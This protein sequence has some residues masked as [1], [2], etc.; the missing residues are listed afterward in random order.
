MV[1]TVF[2]KCTYVITGSSL[3][4]IIVII[5]LISDLEIKPPI[6]EDD[7]DSHVIHWVKHV[8]IIAPPSSIQCFNIIIPVVYP[9]G[10]VGLE[11]KLSRKLI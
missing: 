2:A 10:L 6:H 1:P 8:T 9:V 11:P 5:I 4:K 7:A 3:H